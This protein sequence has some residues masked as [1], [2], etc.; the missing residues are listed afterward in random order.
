MSEEL[1]DASYTLPRTMMYS[2]LAN[3]GMGIVMII[4][5]AYCIGDY[6]K[7]KVLSII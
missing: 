3:G 1:H 7:G 6:L 2:T 4:S 5:Y